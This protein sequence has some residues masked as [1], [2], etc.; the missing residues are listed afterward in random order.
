MF[1]PWA[2]DSQFFWQYPRTGGWEC[3]RTPPLHGL[4]GNGK[5]GSKS[6]RTAITTDSNTYGNTRQA[7]ITVGWEIFEDMKLSLY[8]RLDSYH[9]KYHLWN[10]TVR[11][12]VHQ[13]CGQLH[14]NCIHEYFWFFTKFLVLRYQKC[15]AAKLFIPTVIVHVFMMSHMS[16][17]LTI[18]YST[19]HIWFTL[20][21][22]NAHIWTSCF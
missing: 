13:P 19:S 10:N 15:T 17:D 2:G 16:H 22:G 21:V 3:L 12:V 1:P 18:C 4:L 11:V 5:E 7:F 9:Q 6:R 20:C 8:L 14:D